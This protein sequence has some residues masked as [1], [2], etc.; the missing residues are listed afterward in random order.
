MWQFKSMLSSV[1]LL[2]HKGELIIMFLD[3]FLVHL[4][5]PHSTSSLGYVTRGRP[6]YVWSSFG[7]DSVPM[8]LHL[9]VLYSILWHLL[10][11]LVSSI[12]VMGGMVLAK[13]SVIWPRLYMPWVDEVTVGKSH[14]VIDKSRP[15]SHITKM[16]S[17]ACT[18]PYWRTFEHRSVSPFKLMI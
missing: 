10:L 13:N 17:L 16:T 2:F 14:L 6:R 15:L 1:L 12:R 7:I 5:L 4:I 8:S 3:Q 9:M 18:R 11:A